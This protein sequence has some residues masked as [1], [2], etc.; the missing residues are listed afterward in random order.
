MQDII[1][2]LDS[3]GMSESEIKTYLAVFTHGPSSAR[4][5]AKRGYLSRQSVYTAIQ[6]LISLGF[7]TSKQ[8]DGKQIF[9]AEHPRTILAYAK[10]EERSIQERIKRFEQS[11][12]DIELRM[13][14]DRP[15]VRLYEGKEGI[16]AII[17]E[18]RK[19]KP[20]ELHE[21]TDGKAMMRVLKDED[22]DPYRD[23]LRK[24]KTRIRSILS[25]SVRPNPKGISGLRKFLPPEDSDFQCHIQVSDDSVTFVTFT[26]KLY[27]VLI[28]N[29]AIAHALAI[30]FTHARKGLDG[31][32]R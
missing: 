4:E 19:K 26:G 23:T 30:L 5:I 3:L 17:E 11:L 14:G 13:G 8:Q 6:K 22:L 32:N 10:R 27:S 25:G 20:Q 9:I 1:R 24:Q 18:L 12:S 31:P 7:F 16:R 2:M 21:M 15:V 29:K 28:E